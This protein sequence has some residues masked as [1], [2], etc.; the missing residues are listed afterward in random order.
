MSYFLSCFFPLNDHISKTTKII[1]VLFFYLKILLLLIAH[2][3]FILW[4]PKPPQ[5]TFLDQTRQITSYP[6]KLRDTGKDWPATLRLRANLHDHWLVF[7]CRDLTFY[8]CSKHMWLL[9][10]YSHLQQHSC[11][12]RN[13]P[14]LV[15]V[16]KLW[17]KCFLLSDFPRPIIA[18]LI[19]TSTF[20][21]PTYTYHWIHS[22][23]FFFCI[24]MLY[25]AIGIQ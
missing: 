24:P 25:W 14:P 2:H 15:F 7:T 22:V 4:M 18:L 13:L 10:L 6:W 12:R 8:S 19:R 21:L 11:L 23:I 9:S 16:L 17:F 5:H 20:D 3:V 1:Y